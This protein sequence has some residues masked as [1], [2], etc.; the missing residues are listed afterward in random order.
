MSKKN[1]GITMR[2]VENDTYPE[3]RDT[4][5]HDWIKYLNRFNLNYYLI[6]NFQIDF[7]IYFK[8]NNIDRIIL[9]NGNDVVDSSGIFLQDASVNGTRNLIELDILKTCI[10]LN[11]PV[12][13]I[14]R[15]LQFL[16][17]FFGGKLEPRLMQNYSSKI[18][19]SK[20]KHKVEIFD[21]KILET[22]EN[23]LID[24]NS[25]HN[26]GVLEENVAEDMT[27]VGR[28]ED[29][30]IEILK[31]KHHRIF[32]IQWHP[33]RD[34]GS[35]NFNHFLFSSFLEGFSLFYD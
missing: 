24:V 20:E 13:G 4:I 15:G 25:F 32:G 16:N 19:H 18:D 22:F 14:C 23:N 8:S 29:G 11:I 33:E 17:C 12:L 10:K 31:H 7:E 26:M 9:S 35:E 21:S 1:I 30:V 6:P 2:L 5:S 27:I 28:A 34:G 3:R